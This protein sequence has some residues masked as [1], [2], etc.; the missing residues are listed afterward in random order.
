[1]VDATLKSDKGTPKLGQAELVVTAVFIILLSGVVI[2][3]NI[4][5][6]SMTGNI[7]L[8]PQLENA[9]NEPVHTIET[10]KSI[11]VFANSFLEISANSSEIFENESIILQA[12]LR[13]DDGSP[14]EN[15]NVEFSFDDVTLGVA[16]TDS[17]GMA[18]IEYF[19]PAGISGEKTIKVEF[20]GYDYINPSSAETQVNIRP[21]NQTR[22]E[23]KIERVEFPKVVNE[24]EEFEVIVFVTSLNGKSENVKIM[25]ENPAGTEIVDETLG[26]CQTLACL[27]QKFIRSLPEINEN[28][29]TVVTWKLKAGLCGNYKLT[30]LAEAENGGKD[31]KDFEVSAICRQIILRSDNYVKLGDLGINVTNIPK[32]IY[33]D[34]DPDTL[35]KVEKSYYGFYVKVFNNFTTPS[36]IYSSEDREIFTSIK[37]VD[38]LG[39]GYQPL[40]VGK[41][42]PDAQGFEGGMSVYP[43]T[44][45]E[46]YVIFSEIDEKAGRLS[47]IFETAKGNAVFDYEVMRG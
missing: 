38:D 19:L 3:Q 21:A 1:M 8:D 22:P 33:Y 16:P 30:V 32:G 6:T 45:R 43:Q 26:K 29:H 41:I 2:A 9:T 35:E 25:L 46:G 39:N 7:I 42:I 36:G 18:A 37:I 34:R 47:L 12:K 4:T 23:F 17:S 13:L 15:Q 44:I 11:D 27:R 31:L 5:N 10:T 14:L 28:E 20:G 40:P 24:S